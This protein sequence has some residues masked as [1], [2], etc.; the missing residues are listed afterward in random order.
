MTIPFYGYRR[1]HQSNFKLKS[2]VRFARVEEDRHLCFGEKR[3]KVQ[4]LKF[5]AENGNLFGYL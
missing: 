3:R 1:S 2:P 4:E 5:P